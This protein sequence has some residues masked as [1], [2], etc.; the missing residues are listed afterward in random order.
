[1]KTIEIRND[2]ILTGGGDGRIYKTR[3]RSIHILHIYKL[4][5]NSY[6]HTLLIVLNC[7]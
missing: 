3:K 5:Y 4:K 7:D 1:M 2:W 6:T